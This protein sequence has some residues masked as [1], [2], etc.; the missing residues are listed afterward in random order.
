MEKAGQRLPISAGS[1][2]IE[3]ASVSRPEVNRAT[4]LR[5]LTKQRPRPQRKLSGGVSQAHAPGQLSILRCH[6]VL[7]TC[8][9]PIS[10]LL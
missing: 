8:T 1:I 6:I 9:A 4:A 3:R 7:A 2:L 5:S 10:P